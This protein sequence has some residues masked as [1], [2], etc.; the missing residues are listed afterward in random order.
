ME[1][2]EEFE[3]FLEDDFIQK[4]NA[5]DGLGEMLHQKISDNKGGKDELMRRFGLTREKE[6]FSDKSTDE[7]SEYED[8]SLNKG[9][10]KLNS[11]Y[12]LK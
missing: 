6:K 11:I 5:D 9:I 4:A 3:E 12:S 2:D 1:G 10:I 8:D 7:D